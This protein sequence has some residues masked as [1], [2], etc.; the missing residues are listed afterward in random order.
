MGWNWLDE[1]VGGPDW[2]LDN[3]FEKLIY[4]C[5]WMFLVFFLWGVWIG[6]T[7]PIS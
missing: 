5:G 7:T 2:I 4:L 1:E 3:W 6:I